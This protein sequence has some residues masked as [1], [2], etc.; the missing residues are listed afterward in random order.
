MIPDDQI[1]DLIS[2]DIEGNEL[3]VLKSI[4]FDKYQIKV[5]SFFDREKSFYSFVEGDIFSHPTNN[6]YLEKFWPE[7]FERILK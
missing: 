1:I 3:E 7:I 2:I 4:D 6:Y 5:I